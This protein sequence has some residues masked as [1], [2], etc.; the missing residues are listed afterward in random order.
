MPMTPSHTIQSGCGRV[1]GI[2]S[3]IGVQ[4]SNIRQIKSVLNPTLTVIAV[5]I[6]RRSDTVQ[7]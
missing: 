3:S 7:S 4:L 2:P 5:A 6:R 1:V